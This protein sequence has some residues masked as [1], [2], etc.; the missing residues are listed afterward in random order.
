MEDEEINVI[1]GSV[2]EDSTAQ[3]GAL[4]E[5]GTSQSE[6]VMT[7]EAWEARVLRFFGLNEALRSDASFEFQRDELNQALKNWANRP[8]PQA[9]IYVTWTF[10]DRVI[11]YA[12]GS[13]RAV[14]EI[15]WS[16]NSNGE[17]V[18]GEPIPVK[19][20]EL[21]EPLSESVAPKADRQRFQ[22]RVEMQL[23]GLLESRD[24]EGRRVRAVGITADVVNANSRRYPRA[25]LA[26]AVEELNSHL[27]E[28]AGQGRLILTGEA[29][30]PSDKGGRPNLLE[31][32]VKWTAVSLD[33]TGKVLLEGTILQTS[34]GKDI[35]VLVE[36][37]VPV[38][39]SMRGYGSAEV[40]KESKRTVQQVVELT[41][42]G[43]DLVAQPSDPNG[44]LT[45]SRLEEKKTMNLEEILALLKEKPEMLE[46]VMKAMNLTDQKSLQEALDGRAELEKRAVEG[47]KAQKE[48]DERKAKEAREGA[49]VEATKDLKYGEAL[50]AMF[51]EA[52][53]NSPAQ[54]PEEVNAFANGKREEYDKIAS[55][56]KL[57]GMGKPVSGI[58]VKGPIFES[59]TGQKEF[60]RVS[61]EINESLSKSTNSKRRNLKDD[62]SPAA[63]FTGQLLEAFDKRFKS[64]LIR[65]HR[66]FQE[67]ETTS[68][69]SLPYSVSRAI[70]EQVYPE[71]VAANI[72]DIGIATQSPEKIF[73]ESYSGES[74][75]VATVTAADV[76]GA[77]GV[78]VALAN[79]RIRPGTVIL[80][81][82]AASTT[83]VEGDDYVINYAEGQVMTLAS[84]TTT[85][86]QAL[87]ITY[88]YDA[89]RKGEMQPIARGK[90]V[91]TSQTL[92]IAADRLATQISS[93][94]VVFSRS[95][96]GYDAVGRTLTSLI[97]QIRVKIEQGMHF[98]AL[99]AALR[100]ANNSGGNFVVGSDSI[101]KL[102]KYVG[103]AKVKVIN[104][105]Y[106]PTF[107]LM[108]T[109]V[110]DLL[111]NWDGFKRDGF[112]NAVLTSAGFSGS[113]KGLP[114]Y[115]VPTAI[116]TDS[117]AMIANREIVQHRVFE[118]MLLKGPFASYDGS[119]NLIA[120][121]QYY[122]QEY[123]GMSSPVI[124]K[125]AYVKIS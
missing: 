38:G 37:G 31:T 66:M 110:S 106:D 3:N 68:D 113:I 49:I 8:N 17:I 74:G 86:S 52:V 19:Q 75:S 16:R 108:S 25:V 53:K 18:F 62:E 2:A 102:V 117:F 51:V 103:I 73:F 100:Q 28:S 71:L 120:A 88:T 83:Y 20:V 78:W 99:A 5:N 85:N 44:R 101:E 10:A 21:F 22:E 4:N 84:G 45:E 118:A 81:N 54:T 14:Y 107:V 34:K 32:I 48:L 46:T 1:D 59:E 89:I 98:A 12:W 56:L 97:R 93:E 87:K 7:R 57:A 47:E 121:D 27:N 123:N 72:Y 60:T 119:G 94:A 40:L 67:A 92:E 105:F 58:E 15:P 69:L 111:S 61:F 116:F 82:A 91:L 124:E 77:H 96:L 23:L 35:Q 70:I 6:V 13:T 79:K 125:A 11:A 24:G 109:T 50:N 26:K 36:S 41:I 95:Q 65:E 63:I 39:V 112:P 90:I 122:V 9:E 33:G 29:E 114:V 30:H 80:T 76:T 115:S 42:T 43:F 55:T 64:E 104:R